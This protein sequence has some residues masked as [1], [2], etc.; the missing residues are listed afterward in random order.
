MK[1]S[2]LRLIRHASFDRVPDDLLLRWRW[3]A[4]TRPQ[5]DPVSCAP[6]WQLAWQEIFNPCGNIFYVE[7]GSSLLLFNICFSTDGKV[8]ILPLE[9]SWCFGQPL[10]GPH[11]PELL[12]QAIEELQCIFHPRPVI[13]MLSGVQPQSPDSFRLYHFFRKNWNFFRHERIYNMTAS[14]ENGM[15]GWL[16]RR[17]ANHRAK[18]RKAFRKARDEG[19]IFERHVPLTRGEANALYARMLDV[20]RKSW[21]GV[22]K[23]GMAESPSK[24]FYAALLNRFAANGSARIIFAVRDGRTIGFIFGSVLGGFYRG[25]QFS[26]DQEFWKLSPGNLMQCEKIAWLCDEGIARYD[27]GSGNGE[28]MA[29][30]KHWAESALPMETWLMVPA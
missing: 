27:L 4:L 20:E 15:R 13:V 22:G 29:Y 18:L 1:E 2:H 24:E 11:A 28:A 5:A 14:L 16:S 8:F 7:N 19:I 23:C 26:F 10:L 12:A 6:D 30:K 21:K 25:Q 17:S 9:S 3:L